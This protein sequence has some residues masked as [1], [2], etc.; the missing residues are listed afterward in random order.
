MTDKDGFKSKE[1]SRQDL[2]KHSNDD[3]MHGSQS[4]AEATS[5]VV[6]LRPDSTPTVAIIFLVTGNDRHTRLK[7]A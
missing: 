5:L 6:F 3:K 7:S 1:G 2:V 4:Q